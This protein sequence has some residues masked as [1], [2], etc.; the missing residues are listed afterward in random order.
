[1]S[2]AEADV[3]EQWGRQ[4]CA[5]MWIRGDERARDDLIAQVNGQL[6]NLG[7]RLGRGW[8]NYDPVIRRSGGHPSSY[9][10]IAQW[11]HSHQDSGQAV[12]QRFIDWAE[13]DQ[14]MLANLPIELQDLA[15][16]THLA[17]VGR[18][19]SSSLQLHLYPWLR[20]VANSQ[21][22]WWDYRDEYPPSLKYAEDAAMEWQ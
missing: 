10:N 8:Q 16:I 14:V 18:G 5:C 2:S 22:R 3:L 12:A 1:M 4:W 20:K 19:Y 7:F 21:G 13:G 15:I 9:A 6:N 11:A 17:E